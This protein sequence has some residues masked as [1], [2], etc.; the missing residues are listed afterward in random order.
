MNRTELAEQ[1][2]RLYSR[3]IGLIDPVRLHAWSDLGLTMPTLKVLYLLRDDP[4]TPAGVLAAQLGVTPSTVTGLVDRLVRQNLVRR[5]EDPLDRRLVRN[6][7]TD[8]G[9]Q[10][11]SDLERRSRSLMTD[12]LAELDDE[13]LGQLVQ[14]L[15]ALLQAAERR[16]ARAAVPS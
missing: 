11:T 2:L 5:N 4:G 9:L 10:A 3:A 16:S 1:T 7:L 15:S 8:E 14:A 6:F 12:I 13:T